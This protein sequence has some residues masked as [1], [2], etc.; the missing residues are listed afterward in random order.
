MYGYEDAAARGER[1][2][3]ASIVRL[4]THPPHGSR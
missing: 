2:E 3:D 1:L 4:K